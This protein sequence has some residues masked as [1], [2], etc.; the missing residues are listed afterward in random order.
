MAGAMT[1]MKTSKLCKAEVEDFI[2]FLNT[3]GPSHWFFNLRV[4]KLRAHCISFCILQWDCCCVELESIDGSP[5]FLMEARTLDTVFDIV[6]FKWNPTSMLY[7]AI[8]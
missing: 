8:Q 7:E 1:A 5:W 3:N 4:E 6:E 2:A